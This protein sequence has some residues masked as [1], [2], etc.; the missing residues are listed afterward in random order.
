[1]YVWMNLASPS[2]L[3]I[4]TNF[5]GKVAHSNKQA[6]M[7]TTVWLCDCL[8]WPLPTFCSHYSVTFRSNY[9]VTFRSQ[10]SVT[11]RSHYSVTFRSHYSVTFR[12][13]YSVTFRLQ[14]S[15][16]FCSHYKW[17]N[18]TLQCDIAFALQCDCWLWPLPTFRFLPDMPVRI[19]AF[20]AG[21]LS[22][23]RAHACWWYGR[24]L[25]H[26]AQ[27]ACQNGVAYLDVRNRGR[28]ASHMRAHVCW[29]CGSYLFCQTQHA[30]QNS[31]I[32]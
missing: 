13:H 25:L 10:Y 6:C 8:L 27:H 16:T 20:L 19:V 17:T 9:S 32:N 11:F 24:D 7:R 4:H 2:H 22:R 30:R 14:Y 29:W 15:V 31:G 26:R 28:G 1:M 3:I 23:V 5:R 21:C 18:N 12:S